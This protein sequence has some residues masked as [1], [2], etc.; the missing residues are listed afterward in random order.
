MSNRLRYIFLTIGVVAIVVMCLTFKVSFVELYEDIC[1]AGYW[2]V[3]ILFLWGLLYVMNALSWLIIIRGSGP[4]PIP[5]SRL[6]RLTVTGFALN[7]AT[8]VGLLGGEPYKIL[9]TTPQL[10]TQRAT[11]SVVLFSMMHVFAHLWFWLTSIALY[12]ILV[13]TGIVPPDLTMSILL[14]LMA[15]FCL[16]GIYLFVKGY[17]NGM[18]V[19]LFQ[20]I[21]HIPGLRG[22]AQRFATTHADDLQKIDRQI[23]ELQGQNR[24]SF[25]AS[26]A[27]EYA[28]RV[29]QS[30]EIFFILLIL[31]REAS[32]LT[33]VQS[34]IILSFTSLFANLLFFFP[35]QIGGREGGFVMSAMQ[36]GM[37]LSFGI[38]ISVICRVRELFWAAAG[39]LFLMFNKLPCR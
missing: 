3:A 31:G 13:M 16:G 4:C 15:I 12:A 33:F 39:M 11:S 26:F 25:Y 20:L 9:E 14:P 36:L 21:A 30:L 37:P 8:P 7:Y 28:G 22:W 24:R 2:L 19:R 5:F 23:S 38:F 32:L 10:G 27:M 34:F 35:L 6:L 17:K 18:V 1:K 29:L